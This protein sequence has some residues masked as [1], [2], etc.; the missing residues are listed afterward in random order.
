MLVHHQQ[1][2]ASQGAAPSELESSWQ[3]LD[4]GAL[5]IL[6]DQ[7]AASPASLA[8]LPADDRQDLCASLGRLMLTW[9]RRLARP[10]LPRTLDDPY[11][12]PLAPNKGMQ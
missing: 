12:S 1:V 11:D 8:T 4:H 3:A 7:L 9:T 6:R 5:T 10:L 2:E